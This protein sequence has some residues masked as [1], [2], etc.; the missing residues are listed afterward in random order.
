[1]IIERLEHELA[2]A[3][4]R[5]DRTN[6]RVA[7]TNDAEAVRA[8]KTV[9]R[10]AELIARVDTVL[11]EAVDQFPTIFD[12]SAAP[13]D[14]SAPG[15]K[16]R[17]EGVDMRQPDVPVNQSA[18][19]DTPAASGK[20]ADRSA[21]SQGPPYAER[22]LAQAAERMEWSA[23]MY[24]KGFASMAQR[25]QDAQAYEL[26][27]ARIE[28]DIAREADRV[29]WAKRMYEKG[30][31]TKATYDAAIL[32]HYEALMARLGSGDAMNAVLER[33]ELLKR[34]YQERAHPSKGNEPGKPSEKPA[35][36]NTSAEKDS[37]GKSSAEKPGQE[38]P[39]EEK[40]GKQNGQE[41]NAKPGPKADPTPSK[42]SP[43]AR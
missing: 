11:V 10:L 41:G 14:R 43:H 1:M 35:Q 33:Y 20:P 28:V 27:K 19:P 26:L 18:R 15:P 40:R 17:F 21:Q 12:F 31:A 32:R 23:R 5:L 37:L 29:E 8:R 9:E 4:V 42:E 16:V 34:Q 39:S 24:E 30:Y 2:L 22:S 6:R 25:D 36:E 13:T 38:N 3:Q 7:S